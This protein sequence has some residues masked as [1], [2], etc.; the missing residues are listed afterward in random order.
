MSIQWTSSIKLTRFFFV[1][2]N[3]TYK[4]STLSQKR[5]EVTNFV[6]FLTLFI[7]LCWR[8][9]TSYYVCTYVVYNISIPYKYIMPCMP[10]SVITHKFWFFIEWFM[11]IVILFSLSFF[12]RSFKLCTSVKLETNKLQYLCSL[13]TILCYLISSCRLV[14]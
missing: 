13:F 7:M 3:K 2:T 10:F 6:I 5:K 11:N 8:H 9:S 1:S 14:S 12:L 4:C